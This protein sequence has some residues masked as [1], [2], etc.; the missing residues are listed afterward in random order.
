MNIEEQFNA[1]AEERYISN[2]VIPVNI[3]EIEL[4]KGDEAELGDFLETPSA[5]YFYS[6]TYLSNFY[7][8]KFEANG[9]PFCCSE[10]YFMYRKCLTFDEYNI[11][12]MENILKEKSPFKN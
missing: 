10:Q 1:L 6:D 12:L 9:I 2:D 7:K 3:N 4:S 8:C 11:D 5:I